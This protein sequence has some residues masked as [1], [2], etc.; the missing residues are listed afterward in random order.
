[1]IQVRG[2]LEGFAD[3][4]EDALIIPV[5]ERESPREGFLAV[6]ND[7]TNGGV[8]SVFETREMEGKADQWSLLHNTGGLRSRRLLLYGAGNGKEITSLSVQRICGAAGRVLSARRVRSAALVV[9]D[10]LLLPGCVQAAVEGVALGQADSSLYSSDS[11][12]L[13]KGQ[14]DRLVVVGESPGEPVPVAEIE[15]GRVMAE[16]T[17]FART[18]GNEPGNVMT[19]SVLARAASDMAERERLSVQILVKEQLEDLGMGALLSVARGSDEPPC[20]I[21]LSYEPDDAERK[22]GQLIALVGKGVT[23]DSGGISIKPADCM[24]EMKYDMCGGAAVIGAMQAIARVRPA[25]RVIGLVPAAENLP[26]GRSYKPGDVVRS[27]SGR[28]IEVINTDAEGRLMLADAITYAA[29]RGATHVVDVATL[30]GACVVALGEVRAGVMGADQELVDDLISAGEQCG[31]RLWQMPVDKEYEEL[32]RSDIADVKNTGNR[33]AGA[34]TAAVFLRSF[35]RSLPWAHLDIAGTAWLE[36]EKP[37]M[38]KG[39]TG[40][41]VRTLA[42]F[43]LRRACNRNRD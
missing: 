35:A 17:N 1:M 41:G 37:Y 2:S 3:L 15:R 23:F 33:T 28:T 38:A 5:L 12:G 43:A 25:V 19:P 39:A 32:I 11:D 24:D 26:S 14:L 34:I 9:R 18:L 22:A 42:N 40:F 10:W 4:N 13:K 27:F 20:L 31:E 36:K 21:V 16:A 6:I 29:E 30:T 7:L 8:A